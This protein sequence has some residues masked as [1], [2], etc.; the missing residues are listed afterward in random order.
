MRISNVFQL[1]KPRVK[2]LAQAGHAIRYVLV[3][4][5]HCRIS[6]LSVLCG[7]AF[8][9]FSAQVRDLCTLH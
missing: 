2:N 3:R 5:W 6:V 8:F 9:G 7:L 4:L 1:T